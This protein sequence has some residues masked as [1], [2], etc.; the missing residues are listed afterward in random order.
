MH[1]PPLN[2]L[3]A[4]EASARH[5]SFKKAG[6]ELCVTQG[7]ISRHVMRLEET[8][9]LK[10]FTRHHKR[11]SLTREGERYSGEIHSALAAI[12]RAT[13]S[14]TSVVD[15]NILKVKV[16][17]TCAIRWLMPRLQRFQEMQP[18]FSVQISTSH[19]P[20]DPDK[21]NFDVSLQY[22]P[23]E[24]DLV[25]CE[26]LFGEILIPVCSTEFTSRVPIETP[27]DLSRQVLLKSV[28]RSADWPRW[29]QM[30][31]ISVDQTAT[32]QIV[33]ENASLTYEA[34]EKG[35]GV[36]LAQSAFVVDELQLGRLVAPIDRR[37]ADE[38]GYYL[39]VPRDRARLRK[40]RAFRKWL[41]NEAATTRKVLDRFSN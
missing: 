31:G 36:A 3:R 35:F 7:A 22:G 39:L 1:L 19:E 17:P 32:R 4:F 33:L 37:I 20:F 26:L 16:P 14:C 41:M 12:A 38:T 9:G 25:K 24:S 28:L 29:F 23:S 6:D 27:L 8:L 13:A 40:V 5:L 15:D 21:D 2:A 11:V 34:A 30:V 10:L 18:A